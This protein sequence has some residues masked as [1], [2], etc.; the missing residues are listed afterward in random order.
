VLNTALLPGVASYVEAD[1]VNPSGEEVAFVY[2]FPRGRGSFRLVE[3]RYRI[4]MPPLEPG[5][6]SGV[7]KW[8]G[9][10]VLVGGCCGGG[11]A[12]GS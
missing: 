4:S 9:G 7:L 1:V 3:G 8:A 2:E 5:R 10:G 12:C 11:G 6:Y